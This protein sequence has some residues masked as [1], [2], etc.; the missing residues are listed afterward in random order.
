[1]LR[2]VRFAAQLGFAI[3]ERTEQAIRDMCGNLEKISAERI[4]V[5]L[6]KLV[7]SDHPEEMQNVYDTGI[8]AMILPEFCA[9]MET[10][11]HNPH[12]IYTVGEHTIRSMQYIRADKVLR[13]TMLLHDVAK[14]VCRTEDENGIHHF[15]GHPQVGAE[16]SRK[17]A[18]QTE[19]RQ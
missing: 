8:A 15:H 4:Q 19:V 13:L 9:V 5:E 12:H 7:T 2:A 10:E 3:E 1:M 17:I 6:V 16:M 14:P 11:Q 18:S